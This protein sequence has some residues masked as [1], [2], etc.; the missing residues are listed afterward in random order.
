MKARVPADV[1]PFPRPPGCSQSLL[2]PPGRLFEERTWRAS[3]KVPSS[4]LWGAEQ[5]A[6][7]PDTRIVRAIPEDVQ[8]A[9]RA[10]ERRCFPWRGQRKL[11]GGAVLKD[12]WEPAGLEKEQGCSKQRTTN[13]FQPC[14]ATAFTDFPHYCTWVPD[15]VALAW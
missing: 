14:Q 6:S 4:A 13:G 8:G 5:R 15:P 7:I 2:C 11:R 10:P 3:Y 12:E 9:L 1:L